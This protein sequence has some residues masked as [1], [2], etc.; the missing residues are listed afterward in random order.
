[1]PKE[2][3]RN[4][5]LNDFTKDINPPPPPRFQLS[6]KH[7]WVLITLHTVTPKYLGCLFAHFRLPFALTLTQHY[8]TV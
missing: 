4:L 6:A 1:M 5:S 7:C 3:K 8:P 2:K